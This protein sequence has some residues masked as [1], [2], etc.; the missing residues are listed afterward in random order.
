MSYIHFQQ[1]DVSSL[2]KSNYKRLLTNYAKLKELDIFGEGINHEIVS[3]NMLHSRFRKPL[4]LIQTDGCK[5]MQNK[6]QENFKKNQSMLYLHGPIGIGKSH[7]ILAEVLRLRQAGNIVIYINNPEKWTSI[8]SEFSYF[9]NELVYASIP[10]QTKN[11]LQ[12]SS[13]IEQYFGKDT[14]PLFQ[15]Y[16][17]L[18]LVENITLDS[19]EQ[20]I[21]EFM[22][23]VQKRAYE[24][25]ITVYYFSDQENALMK[26]NSLQVSFP[27]DTRLDF[28]DNKVISAS[29]N[30]DFPALQFKAKTVAVF[31]RMSSN[32]S[33]VFFL[34]INIRERNLKYN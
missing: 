19:R 8:G 6:I 31:Q 30:T 9:I 2:Q 1:I 18:K 29:A 17:I 28:G 21:S 10:L 27:F 14:E 4:S 33:K 20:I 32:S 11:L 23:E 34:I 25:R 3:P 22:A 24:A 7:A 5:E 16:C 13:D 15:W 12:I 26:E